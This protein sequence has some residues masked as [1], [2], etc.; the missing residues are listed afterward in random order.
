MKKNL[1]WISALLL[2]LAG[3]SS[4]DDDIA[5]NDRNI[6]GYWES[7]G[8]IDGRG[9]LL[10]ASDG[11][12]KV[13]KYSLLTGTGQYSEGHWGY[14]WFDD[15]GTLEIQDRPKDSDPNPDELYYKVMSLTKDRLVIR[16]FGG[17]AGTPLEKGYDIVYLKTDKPNK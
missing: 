7:T 13:W 3:C 1:L 16:H 9:G 15:D 8:T 17:F 2:M 10:F 4:S 14:F 11:E 5:I 12:I 6:L